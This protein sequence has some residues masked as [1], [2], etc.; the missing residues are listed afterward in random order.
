MSSSTPPMMG[1][2]TIIGPNDGKRRI[3]HTMV[4]THDLDAS[5]HF[6]CDVLG[7]KVLTERMESPTFQL[8]AMF[9]GFKSAED[10]GVMIEL[11]EPWDKTEA[12]PH[13]RGGTHLAIGVADS[14]AMVARIE[15]AGAEVEWRGKVPFASDPDGYQIEIIQSLR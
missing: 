6:Y 15:A 14:A 7:M 4:R 10:G 13:V 3:L 11:V 12:L 9:V 1:P 8:T 5:T 2:R